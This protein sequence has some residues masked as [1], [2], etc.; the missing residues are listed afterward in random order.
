MGVRCVHTGHSDIR[1]LRQTNNSYH[2][3]HIIELLLRCCPLQRCPLHVVSGYCENKVCDGER[4]GEVRGGSLEVV[5]EEGG[6]G[7][8]S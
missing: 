1:L 8:F 2:I 5:G 3:I 6:G 7:G 4:R